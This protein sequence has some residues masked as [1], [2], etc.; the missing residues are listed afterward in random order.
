MILRMTEK[1]LTADILSI[2]TTDQQDHHL[3]L[4][5]QSLIFSM[6]NDFEKPWL[7]LSDTKGYI[8][9]FF[10]TLYTADKIGTRT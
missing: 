4:I 3:F 7:M 2:S 9:C 1:V 8:Q 5:L 10:H 6:E